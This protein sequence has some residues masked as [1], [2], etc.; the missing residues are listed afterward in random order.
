[1]TESNLTVE[2][3]D[4]NAI[5]AELLL[6][7]QELKDGQER[8]RKEFEAEKA[9]LTAQ[10]E[11]VKADAASVSV[12]RPNVLPDNAIDPRTDH[13]ET[14]VEIRLD[15]MEA[16]AELNGVVFDRERNRKILNGEPVEDLYLSRFNGRVFDTQEEL[17]E[18]VNKATVEQART[19]GKY[20]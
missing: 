11:T 20:R 17:D 6:A 18:Y 12:G 13:P 2:K 3:V 7:V 16:I 5:L 8:Q 9:N 15:C 10:L 4:S 1:M 19:L 14:N